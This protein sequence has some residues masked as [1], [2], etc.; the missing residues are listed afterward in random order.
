MGLQGPFSQLFWGGGPRNGGGDSV[1]TLIRRVRLLVPALPSRAGQ[2]F[3]LLF[4]VFSSLSLYLIFFDI[5]ILYRI[6]FANVIK[7]NFKKSLL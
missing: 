3:I 7:D 2:F 4:I 6:N 1:G 5:L